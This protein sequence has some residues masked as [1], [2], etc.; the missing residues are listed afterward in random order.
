[1][2][3]TIKQ[4]LGPSWGPRVQ[5]VRDATYGRVAGV[6]AALL[7]NLPVRVLVRINSRLPRVMTM[8]YDKA[9]IRL[10]VTSLIE[11]TSRLNSCKKEPETVAWLE[12]SFASGDVLYD[13]GANVGTYSLLA[14]RVS[15]GRGRIYSF[16]PGFSTF[17]KLC[18]NLMLNGTGD[19][20]VPLN[21]ALSSVTGW[22]EF[23][24]TSMDAGNASQGMAVDENSSKVL[25]KQ[26][27]PAYAMDDLQERFALQPPTHLKIDVDG[28]EEAILNGAANILD[29]DSLRSILI[30]IDNDEALAE[31]VLG[32]LHGHGWRVV[33]CHPHILRGEVTV[34]NYVLG[35]DVARP[36]QPL[37]RS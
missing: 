15:G 27:M 23:S 2:K 12:E 16:E 13:V 10:W 9:P 37:C 32:I 34:T 22:V 28:Y 17:P 14:W 35:R 36:S 3:A 1:M 8:D 11:V 18:Q 7:R 25:F 24:Y 29:S 21:V 19:T 33:S 5:A 20:V 6:L 4:M 31:R 30:E 26:S